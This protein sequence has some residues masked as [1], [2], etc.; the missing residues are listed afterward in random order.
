MEKTYNTFLIA[1]ATDQNSENSAHKTLNEYEKKMN[2]AGQEYITIWNFDNLESINNL[3]NLENNFNTPVRSR[4]FVFVD[5]SFWNKSSYSKL[6]RFQVIDCKPTA[7][8]MNFSSHPTNEELKK[9]LEEMKMELETLKQQAFEEVSRKIKQDPSTNSNN[10]I[11][12][13]NY[14]ELTES[15]IFAVL[16][17]VP[18]QKYQSMYDFMIEFLVIKCEDKIENLQIVFNA[19]NFEIIEIKLAK[20]LIQEFNDTFDFVLKITDVFRRMIKSSVEICFQISTSYPKIMFIKGTNSLFDTN[21]HT[22]EPRVKISKVR[23]PGLKANT[24]VISKAIV[25]TK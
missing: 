20:K 23:I 4:A 15:N 11:L 1:Q 5:E 24:F 13:Q 2:K 14:E 17:P 18:E 25:L 22:A 10:I 3:L 6:N 9:L 12:K 7:G 19:T 21:E 16:E 8:K